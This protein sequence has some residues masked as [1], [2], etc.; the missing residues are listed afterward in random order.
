MILKSRLERSLHDGPTGRRDAEEA[1]R[2]RWL[3]VLADLVRHS[4]TP[5][6]TAAHSSA[7]LR[8][9]TGRWHTRVLSNQS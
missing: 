2:Q 8:G 4:P 9:G 3:H 6:G 5:M 1:E 7:Q